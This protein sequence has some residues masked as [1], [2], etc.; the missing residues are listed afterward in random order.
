MTRF[1]DP[2]ACAAGASSV[3]TGSRM[4]SAPRVSRVRNFFQE[5][6]VRPPQYLRGRH[7]QVRRDKRDRSKSS[8]TSGR[9]EQLNWNPA[10]GAGTSRWNPPSRGST[11]PA[12][13]HAAASELPAGDARETRVNARSG[14]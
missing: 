6:I 11:N 13:R 10:R 4:K 5:V 12:G 3:S 8:E 1:G 2:V 7:R 9:A 14:D